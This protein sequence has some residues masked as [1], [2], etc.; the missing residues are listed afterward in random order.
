[1]T[2]ATRLLRAA[3]LLFAVAAA[4]TACS[5][6]VASSPT[7]GPSAASPAPVASAQAPSS[8]PAG[9]PEGTATV[10]GGVQ[11]ISIDLTKGYFDPSI[12]HAKAG[13]PLEIAFGQGSGCLARV[14]FP[15]FSVDQDL[16]NGGATVSLPAMKAGEYGFSCGMHMVYGKVIAQ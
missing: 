5:A 2:S 8:V 10:D 7:G 4:T 15:D 11:R 13:V 3:A 12:I 9:A 1:M 16:T 14:L 6:P